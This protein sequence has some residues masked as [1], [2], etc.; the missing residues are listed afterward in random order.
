MCVNYHLNPFLILVVRNG[1][2]FL[3][4]LKSNTFYLHCH[5]ALILNQLRYWFVQ[6]NGFGNGLN[7]QRQWNRAWREDEKSFVAFS[8]FFFVPLHPKWRVF[9]SW[10]ERF[11]FLAV[12]HEFAHVYMMIKHPHILEPHSPEF[13]AMEESL[14]REFGLRYLFV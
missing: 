11:F 8:H 10:K 2:R 1:Q 14:A 7:V 12:L 9:R 3:L 5:N 13:F 4:I 6:K